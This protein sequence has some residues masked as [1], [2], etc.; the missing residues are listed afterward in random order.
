MPS[1]SRFI[2]DVPNTKV[3]SSFCACQKYVSEKWYEKIAAG[4]GGEDE[5]KTMQCKIR[6]FRHHVVKNTP[7]E[8]F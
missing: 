4:G 7:I 1:R 6:A 3:F 8:V 2:F 5:E